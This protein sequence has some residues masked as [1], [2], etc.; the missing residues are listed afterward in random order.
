MIRKIKLFKDFSFFLKHSCFK[1][2]TQVRRKVNSGNE[3]S[4]NNDNGVENVNEFVGQKKVLNKIVSD[5]NENLKKT[6][7]NEIVSNVDEIDFSKIFIETEENEFKQVDLSNMDHEDLNEFMTYLKEI[8]SKNILLENRKNKVE[9]KEEYPQK[10][11]EF[12]KS[13]G[14]PG[15]NSFFNKNSQ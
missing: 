9:I 6:T 5:V 2:R 15:N 13:E 8:N 1:M 3:N 4:D 14:Y 7:F 12:L 10:V 11:V